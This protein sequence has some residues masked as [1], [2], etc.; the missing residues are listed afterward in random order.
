MTQNYICISLSLIKKL[1]GLGAIK[2][3]LF[4]LLKTFLIRLR[5]WFSQ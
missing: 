5:P 2:A 1:K 3:G 4:N